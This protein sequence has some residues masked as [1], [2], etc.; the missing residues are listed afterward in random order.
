[1]KLT[2]I[3][4]LGVCLQ[5]SAIGNAQSVSLSEKNTDLKKVFKQIEKQTGYYFIYRDEL[6]K[7]AGK[8]SI[9]VKNMP[10]KEVLEKCLENQPLT[11]SIV[12]KLIVIKQKL[13][14]N[15]PE[16]EKPIEEITLILIKGTI[17][18][19]LGQP[20]AGATV[21]IKGT[22]INTVTNTNG[23]FTINAQQGQILVI[24]YVGYLTSEYKV[25]TASSFSISLTPKRDDLSNVVI[26][27]TG[28]Q[29][30]P[31]DRSAGS[32]STVTSDAIQQKTVSMNVMDRLE[33]LVAGLTVNNSVGG[34]KYL[35]RGLTT[36]YGADKQ[37][38]V[39]VDGVP[40]YNGEPPHNYAS[41]ET[42]I[43]PNDVETISFL[44]D[45]TASSIWGAAAANGVIVITTKKGS[46]KGRKPAIGY[47]GFVTVKGVPD[48]SYNKMMNSSQLLQSANEI[49]SPNTITWAAISSSGSGNLRP[50][51]TPH[52]QIMY[53]RYRGIINQATA[54]ARLDS[55]SWLNN[56]SQVNQ[57]LRQSS[58]LTNH[59]VTINGGSDF[60]SYYGSFGFTNDRSFNKTNLSRYQFNM[61]QDFT[62]SPKVK[63]DLTTNVSYEQSQDFLLTDLPGNANLPYIMYADESG[64]PLS[65]AY[66]IRHDP[67]RANSETLSGIS[68]D[69]I[70]LEE[71]GH[72]KNNSTNLAARI[73]AGLSVKLLKGLTYEARG[74]YQRSVQD[75]YEYYDQ[76]SF[77]VRQE[78]M[79][80]TSY[81]NGVR[82]NY[83]PTS[84]GTYTTNN[85]TLKAW[86]IRNQL[87]Y[88]NNF[89]GKH[90][91]TGLVGTETRSSVSTP[92][93]T[94]T[95]G[96]D[97]QTQRYEVYDEKALATTGVTFPVEIKTSGTVNT[98]ISDPFNF[99]REV[100]RRFF[101]LYGNAA[102]TYSRRYTFNGSIRMDQSNLFGS[103]KSVQYKPVWSV[104]GSWAVSKESFFKAKKINNLV[105]RMTYGIGGNPPS[106]GD[107]GPYD[108]VSG[109]N[110]SIFA[111][112]G[113]GYV[114][115]TPANN[116][117]VWEQTKTTN[118][119]VDFAVFNSRISGSVDVYNKM[120][121]DLLGY[122]PVDP[123][124]GWTFVYSNLGSMSNKGV[125][126]QINSKNIVKKNFTWNT[127]LTLSKNTNKIIELKRGLPLTV[128]SKIG[129]NQLEGYTA[130]PLFGY[131]FMGLNN[132]G[133]P[134]VRGEKGDTILAFAKLGIND[135]VFAG[136]TQPPWS[137][138][139]TNI[140]N[141]K[142]FS[143]SFLV[144]YNFGH[145]MRLDVNSFYTGRLNRNYPVYFMDR[146]R[147]PGDEQFTDVPRYE[148]NNSANNTS[149]RYVNL[150]TEGLNNIV[151]AA[152]A[153]LRDMTLTYNFPEVGL[154]KLKLANLSIYGQ[155][156]N[157]LLWTKNTYDIDPEYHNLQSGSR[158]SRMPA[159]YT[160]GVKLG[161]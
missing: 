134:M 13:S 21:N 71:P 58:L 103:D 148:P 41:L 10:V 44:K 34:E 56:Q 38:L 36:V 118:I 14:V 114:I 49:F 160:L 88:D 133:N 145:K 158:G 102:Y 152:Y 129:G 3:L 130:F 85:S 153:K 29:K 92:K 156:N 128:S 94:Y 109:R 161:F 65:M 139:I 72:T 111:G 52:E 137:G 11:F 64:K 105:L 32:F 80:Y 90:Q 81:Q 18:D 93:A 53:D 15:N 63:F 25:S 126:I 91:L 19:S 70:P 26:V 39:V 69:Y 50:V 116:R 16:K 43:N 79:W 157:I 47:S 155:V 150:Y 57:Y 12:D 136:T 23:T 77:K 46:N 104:G 123:T 5:A 112:L 33:G 107:G 121:D 146:W 96:Y 78:N 143:L 115:L 141:C 83:L 132:L 2:A 76:Y 100:D 67:F 147:T 86:T 149:S 6:L 51:V 55:L 124:T 4:L 98:L 30:L 140:I 84:G 154:Q 151:S 135:P 68:L 22:K 73:N 74:Q 17:T 117:L 97:F 87:L 110:N 113:P 127:I 54:D 99:Y 120:S 1:M 48:Q 106:P 45:A 144:I 119:G 31:K 122:A 27:S 59:T 20:L 9:D 89:G 125:E 82:T 61:K 95:R 142:Q 60:H 75:S 40:L 42:L 66:L 37:P 8:V 35:M 28:Y 131:N 24:S 108:I 101:S 7:N 159:F 62:F 138:G